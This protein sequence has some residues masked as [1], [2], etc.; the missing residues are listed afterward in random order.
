MEEATARVAVAKGCASVDLIL[1]DRSGPAES[2]SSEV[3]PSRGAVA[4]ALAVDSPAVTIVGGSGE[5]GNVP[6]GEDHVR[7]QNRSKVLVRVGKGW[8]A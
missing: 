6:L 8:H 4:D 7:S 5:S 1:A 3:L 2:G